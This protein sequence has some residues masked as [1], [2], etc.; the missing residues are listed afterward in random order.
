MWS[1]PEAIAEYV[2]CM[3]DVLDQ[4]E[5]PYDAQYPQVCF[6]EGLNQ[7]IEETRRILKKLEFHYTPKHGQLAEHGENRV[8]CVQ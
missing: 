8:E 1:I 6:D 7:L 5:R 4:Y 3:E 2:A